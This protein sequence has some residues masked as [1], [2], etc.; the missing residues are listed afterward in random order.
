MTDHPRR[1]PSESAK[2]DPNLGQKDAE[3]E[4][5]KLTEANEEEGDEDPNLGQKDAEEERDELAE[6]EPKTAYD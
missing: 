6:F 2:G 3:R 5:A 4:K 1:S